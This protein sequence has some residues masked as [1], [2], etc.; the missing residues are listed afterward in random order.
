MVN[1]EFLIKAG[2]KFKSITYTLIISLIVTFLFVYSTTQYR[3]EMNEYIIFLG[4]LLILWSKVL[5]DIY[6]AGHFLIKSC[7]DQSYSRPQTFN[8]MLRDHK[9]ESTS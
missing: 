9:D 4:I 8:E 1:E 3:P 6:K 2:N 5:I 7:E